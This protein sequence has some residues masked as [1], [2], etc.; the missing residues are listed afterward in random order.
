MVMDGPMS[1]LYLVR[2][3]WRRDHGE[4]DEVPVEDEGAVME[5]APVVASSS[6]SVLHGMSHRDGPRPSRLELPQHF[7]QQRD[8]RIIIKI[9]KP[10]SFYCELTMR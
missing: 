6:S 1:C 2:S 4:V 7:L 5:V 9:V 8:C 10:R 3:H